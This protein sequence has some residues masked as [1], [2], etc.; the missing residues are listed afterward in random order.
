MDPPIRG[1]TGRLHRSVD[2]T[3]TGDPRQDRLPCRR[4]LQNFAH[5]HHYILDDAVENL[6]N[7]GDPL[8]DAQTPVPWAARLLK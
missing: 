6:L 1:H 2:A 4:H 7:V 5:R 8:P 3:Q